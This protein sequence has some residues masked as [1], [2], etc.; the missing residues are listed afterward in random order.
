M[1]FPQTSL[2]LLLAMGA[3]AYGVKNV[4]PHQLPGC[5]IFQGACQYQVSVTGSNCMSQDEP[6]TSFQD[7][8][9]EAKKTNANEEEEMKRLDTLE[10]KLT[11]MMEGLSIRSLRHIRQI[12]ND[13]REMSMT[14]N[15]L[16]HQG[17]KRRRGS[18][19]P[20]EFTS[21]GTW[22]SCYRF[23]TFNATWHEAREYCAAFGADLV[24]PDT[25]KEAYIMDYL[26]KS[27]PGKFSQTEPIKLVGPSGMLTSLLL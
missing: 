7:I 24:S 10:K 4:K 26:I 5:T 20:P 8:I 23:S 27:N 14:M 19:C 2:V 22:T 18:T 3:A 16:K 9:D 13:L 12:R 21:V 25:M 6:A 15:L 1:A 17:N 11:K